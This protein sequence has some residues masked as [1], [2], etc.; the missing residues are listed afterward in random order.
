MPERTRSSNESIDGSS[1]PQNRVMTLEGNEV[2]RCDVSR[3]TSTDL[4]SFCR[5]IDFDVVLNKRLEDNRDEIPIGYLDGILAKKDC[6]F[7]RLVAHSLV[8]FTGQYPLPTVIEGSRVKC[9]LRTVIGAWELPVPYRA[10]AQ[11]PHQAIRVVTIPPLPSC[12]R[13]SPVNQESLQKWM[14]AARPLGTPIPW[15]MSFSR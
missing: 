1:W 6:T 5:T 3:Q 2:W 12:L 13:E 9:D 4:C 11:K 14:K 8:K 7:C 15:A 10:T